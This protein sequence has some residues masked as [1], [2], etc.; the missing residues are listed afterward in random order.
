[1]CQLNT[2]KNCVIF[3]RRKAEN[4][5]LVF[6]SQIWYYRCDDVKK[7][8]SVQ[9]D[10]AQIQSLSNAGW[11]HSTTVSVFE[12]IIKNS[13]LWTLDHFCNNIFLIT[14]KYI[15]FYWYFN[16]YRLLLRLYY[17]IVLWLPFTTIAIYVTKM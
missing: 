10:N 7:Y 16:L 8:G 3:T 6:Y 15:I 2:N 11:H 17:I 9:K 13:I 4:V 1:M 5:D 12:L 14:V